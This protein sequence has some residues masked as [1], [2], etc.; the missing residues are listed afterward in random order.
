MGRDVEGLSFSNLFQQVVD[1]VLAKI[2]AE[3]DDT[4]ELYTLVDE[5]N[6]IVIEEVEPTFE[7]N[8]QYNALCKLYEKAGNEEK[9]L[10]AWSKYV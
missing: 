1:T 6:D 7:K 2:L 3:T 5:P 9:L 4:S 10:E 8:G